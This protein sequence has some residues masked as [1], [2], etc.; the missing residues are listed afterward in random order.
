MKRSP[1]R[2]AAL[3]QQ[4]RQLSAQRTAL[5]L[6]KAEVARAVGI[7]APQITRWEDGETLIS[8]FHHNLLR[9]YFKRVAEEQKAAL[10]K[11]FAAEAGATEVQP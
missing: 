9:L 3:Q 6:S 8:A 10:A 11:V 1:Q 2:A 4:A 5:G 7:A